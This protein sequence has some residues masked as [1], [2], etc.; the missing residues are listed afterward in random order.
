ME[1]WNLGLLES[2]L[3]YTI[4]MR[5]IALILLWLITDALVFVG[6]YALAYF[7]KVGWIFS[8][9]LPFETFASAVLITTA[10]WLIVMMTMRNFG[11]TRK[12]AS[13]RNFAY[14]IYACIKI[15]RAHV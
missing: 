5:R 1:S 3:L 4:I 11:L 10:G 7:I 6:A 9:D 15:G 13:I 12:Q 2:F 14:I 8:S